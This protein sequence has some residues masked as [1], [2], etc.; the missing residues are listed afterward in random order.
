MRNIWVV[1]RV[2]AWVTLCIVFAFGLPAA[3]QTSS[4]DTVWPHTLTVNGANVV[5]YQPQAIDWPDHATL[6]TREAIAITR[7]S[8][9]TPVL[10]STEI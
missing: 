3:A 9:K 5:V 2:V 8:D 10:G 1:P 4:Q 6:T 7:A